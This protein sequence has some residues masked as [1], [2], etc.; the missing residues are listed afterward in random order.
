MEIYRLFHNRKLICALLGLLLLN[1]V[2]FMLQNPRGDVEKILQMEMEQEEHRDTYQ[3]YVSEVIDDANRIVDSPIFV[4]KNSEFFKNNASNIANAYE[5]VKDITVEDGNDVPI[6]AFMRFSLMPYIS[7]IMLILIAFDAAREQKKGISF[8]IYT[9]YK[10][11]GMLG[12]RRCGYIVFMSGVIVAVNMLMLLCLSIFTYGGEVGFERSVQSISLFRDFT[13]LM[14]IRGFL[15]RY[16][17]L[18]VLVIAIVGIFVWTCMSLISNLL[19]SMVVLSGVFLTEYSWMKSITAQSNLRLLKYVN[20]LEY[21]DVEDYLFKYYD[22]NIGGNAVN[23]LWIIKPGILLLLA[24]FSAVG[25][26][27]FARRSINTSKRR[28]FSM[29][30]KINSLQEH[31][32]L[33]FAELHKVLFFNKAIWVIVI[34]VMIASGMVNQRY[35]VYTDEEQYINSFYENYSG[36]VS[37]DTYAFIESEHAYITEVYENCAQVSARYQKGEA[38]KTEF[39]NAQAELRPAQIAERGLQ[40]IEAEVLRAE[41]LQ[42][43]RGIQMHLLNNSGYN[44]LLGDSGRT[45]QTGIMIVCLLVFAI[46]FSGNFRYEEKSQSTYLLRTAYRGRGELVHAKEWTVCIIACFVYGVLHMV[47][48][49]HIMTQYGLPDMMAPVQSIAILQSFPV[50]INIL[51]YLVGVVLVRLVVYILIAEWLLHLSVL[52]EQKMILIAFTVLM[53]LPILLNVRV[54]SYFDILNINGIVMGQVDI[55]LIVVKGIL[56]TV[57]AVVTR[58]LAYKKWCG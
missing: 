18:L 19:L 22:L 3:A 46:V 44:K 48:I 50:E 56:L 13:Y 10:G 6:V 52:V 41:E 27:A 54:I 47:H 33:V 8:M 38:D 25:V 9:S 23:L 39:I 51:T 30:E 12:M 55:F 26:F 36:E 40:V 4:S 29:A 31:Y 21:L 28:K 20:V 17:L 58:G 32:S 16:Y 45:T 37:E 2:I 14:S 49:Y 5:G 35:I 15:L 24:V 57:I 53:L 42:M 7:L 43:K 11:R 34:T 1:A